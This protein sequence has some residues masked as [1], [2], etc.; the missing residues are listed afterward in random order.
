MNYIHQIISF[1]RKAQEIA[2]LHG[3]QNIL[4]PGLVKELVVADILGHEVPERN[5][6]PMPTIQK[7]PLGNSNIFHALLAEHFNWIECSSRQQTSVQNR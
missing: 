2:S 4:Q 5:M 1:I 6:N 3:L 7:T